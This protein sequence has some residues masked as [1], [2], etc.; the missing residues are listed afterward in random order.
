MNIFAAFI[1][2]LAVTISLKAQADISLPDTALEI[3]VRDIDV[4][5]GNIAEN[6]LRSA[7]ANALRSHALNTV[8]ISRVPGDDHSTRLIFRIRIGADHYRQ[9]IRDTLDR[10][11]S[12]ANYISIRQAGIYI[13]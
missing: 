4:I 12:N 5:G 6:D 9:F 13:K 10:H 11:E 2:G 3:R 7:L 1:F 8:D